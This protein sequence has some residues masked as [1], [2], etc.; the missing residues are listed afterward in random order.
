MVPLPLNLPSPENYDNANILQREIAARM[1]ERLDYL[2]L[3]PEVI[4]DLGARTGFGT[5]LLRQRFPAALSV[6]IDVTPGILRQGFPAEAK[7]KRLIGLGDS[8][9]ACTSAEFTRLPLRD[10]SA[11]MLWS[12]LALHYHD[13]DSVCKEARRVLKPGGLFMFS[14]FGP[15][16]L[17]ELRAVCGS[18]GAGMK[19][20]IDM[21]D[22]GDVLSHNGFTA[23]VM[24]MET[25]KLTYS[26]TTDLL[27]DLRNTGEQN[28]L[29][30]ILRGEV[31]R[32][33][34]ASFSRLYEAF[35]ADGKLPATYEIIYGHAWNSEGNK[36]LADGSQIIEF[37][38]YKSAAP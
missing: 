17:K 28:L 37:R 35:R 27:Q 30:E 15:D 22:V 36:I 19:R 9:F 3:A 7:W 21:H 4:L 32:D 38:K 33:R 26:D 31:S 24:D 11:D 12:N 18:D 14:L 13:P 16:T 10:A 25:L 23:P 2:K 5:R 6:P 34:I 1:A 20:L 8:P 29:P